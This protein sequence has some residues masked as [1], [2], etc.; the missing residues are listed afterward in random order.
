MC[1]L[2][3]D[4]II[5]GHPHVVQPMDLLESTTDPDHKTV[6]LYS[7]GNAVSNQRAG[8]IS[9]ISTAHTED[10]VLFSITFSKYSDGTVYLEDVDLVPTWV[11]MNSNSGSR[12]YNIV[13][14]H[15][16]LR[17]QWQT[18]FNMSDNDFNNAQRSYDRTDAI[19]SEGLTKSK[20][21]LA[22]Q[23]QQREDDYQAQAQN[24]A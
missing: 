24:A 11:Y 18:D 3:V 14:L 19:V 15:N 23:K 21:Y 5:G 4:V 8:N 9:S 22:Q 1:D 7:M 6:I 13:P 10:G 20:E 17:D 2:G 12:Q 16:D